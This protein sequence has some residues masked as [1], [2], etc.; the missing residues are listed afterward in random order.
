MWL[1]AIVGMSPERC[2]TVGADTYPRAT[3]G[4]RVLKIGEVAAASGV[5]VD[6]VRFYE[7]RGVL[8]DAKRLPSGY[9]VFD[10][11]AVERI[12]LV[13]SLQALGM[14]LD[15]VVD[16]LRAVD[17][18]QGSCVDERWRLQVVLERVD[19]E[20]E[21][22]TALRRDVVATLDGCSDGG[23]DCELSPRVFG[24]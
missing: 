8:P 2:A 15:E 7:R 19:A 20:I 3:K 11:E 12:R 14:T 10:P 21:R 1:R 17:A 5:S 24:I 9:R 22:L 23:G 18:G 16:G 6:T 4:R 13:K